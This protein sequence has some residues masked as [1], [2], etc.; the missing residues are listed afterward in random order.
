M[1][2]PKKNAVFDFEKGLIE[3]EKIVEQMEQG[4]T[5]L[6]VSLEQF[7][8]AIQLLKS[9]QT[10]LKTAEQQVQILLNKE[11]KDILVPFKVD[12]EFA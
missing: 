6:E 4:N 1:P 3:L 8:K 10:T 7:A 9:C 2:K 5:S 12:E 11:Q